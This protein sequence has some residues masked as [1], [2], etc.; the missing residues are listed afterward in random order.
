[1]ATKLFLNGFVGEVYDF[2]TDE[3]KS[4]SYAG[5]KSN[6]KDVEGDIELHINS[7]GGDAFE[8]MAM[9]ALLKGYEGAKTAIV[10]GFCA[11]AATLPLFAMDSVKAHE[12][13]MFLFHKSGTMAM[14]HA[15]DLRAKADELDTID[16]TVIDL[17]MKKFTGTEDE[18]TELLDS[19]KLITA[20]QALEYGFI[21]EIISD[22]KPQL[23]DTTEVTMQ[24]EESETPEKPTVES[25]GKESEKIIME[26]HTKIETLV[27]IFNNISL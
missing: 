13:S 3:I 4:S 18:L 19:D 26:N 16:S 6:L 5:M 14:G 1:M 25:V 8:G 9:L 7:K 17:Y 15:N 21:D 24:V 23:A 10:D 22:E 20:K 11:S 2:W 12:T 27:D